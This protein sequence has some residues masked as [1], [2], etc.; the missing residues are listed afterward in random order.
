MYY[1]GGRQAV[2][3]LLLPPLTGR[4]DMYMREVAQV[5]NLT[6]TPAS[7]YLVECR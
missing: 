7:T 1:V 6:R 4:Y 3:Y 2:R 5:P